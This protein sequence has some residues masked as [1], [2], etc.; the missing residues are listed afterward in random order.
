M[1]PRLSWGQEREALGH[2]CTGSWPDLSRRHFKRDVQPFLK[3]KTLSSRFTSYC[4]SNLKSNLVPMEWGFA[5]DAIGRFFTASFWSLTISVGYSCNRGGHSGVPV[6]D[7]V[8][9][10]GSSLPPY[11]LFQKKKKEHS[12]FHLWSSIGNVWSIPE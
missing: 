2:L 1:C 11:P 10:T 12:R 3:S 7:G 9:S 4:L 8:L 5:R 6:K